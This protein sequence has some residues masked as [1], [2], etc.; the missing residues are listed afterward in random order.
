M[1]N[2]GILGAGRIGKVH[3]KAASNIK[4]VCI[5]YI[6]DPVAPD[7]EET[8]KSLGIEKMTKD[9]KNVLADKSIDAVF[10]C[11]SSDT[12]YQISIEALEA[13]KHVFC[14]K[15]VDLEIARVA[16][17]KKLVKESGKKY[18]V[19]FNRRFDHNFKALHDNVLS[20]KV[21]K[22]ELIQITSRDPGPPPLEY[23]KVSGGLFCDMMIH[24]FDM[25]RYLSGSEAVSV[26]AYG[27]ALVDPKIKT[28]AR[29][30]DT[31]IVTI[32]LENKAL[33]VITNS[34]RATYGY[35]QRAEVHGEKGCLSCGNDTA[36]TLVVANENGMVH[37]KPL[38]FFLERYMNAY[39]TE[40]EGFVSAVINNTDTPITVDEAFN[41]LVIAKATQKSLNEGR[42]VFIKEILN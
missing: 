38:F 10:I 40:I 41:S 21:G 14:E 1:I 8:A 17:V 33:A 3:G 28:E 7:L 20:G 32:E 27:D 42:K 12:H 5:K 4:D 37:D 26:F 11:T 36:N 29:D 19:G 22:V 13:G 15:P 18:M 35:D 24:D 6:A 34:R 16:D 31:A 9:Y 30:V 25:V 23:L 39:K 2:I